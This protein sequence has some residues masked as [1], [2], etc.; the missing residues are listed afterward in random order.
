M[1]KKITF[2]ILSIASSVFI[3]TGC[4][5]DKNTQN[6]LI[7]NDYKN[8]PIAL[9]ALDYAKK[10]TAGIYSIDENTQHNGIRKI[11]VQGYFK[12]SYTQLKNHFEHIC[13]LKNGKF[14]GDWCY[15]TEPSA[16]P[17][18]GIHIQKLPK[19]NKFFYAQTI[20][21]SFLSLEG[22]YEIKAQNKY[23]YKVYSPND[24]K[25]LKNTKWNDFVR[26]K[27]SENEN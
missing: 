20:T 15:D 12:E 17:L 25:D 27:V 13:N 3:F 5:T 23:S 24:N 14:I 21:G 22:N 9:F 6:K 4:S 10:R 8:E 11:L 26:N 18:F 16:Y 19:D 7:L 2:T 1:N